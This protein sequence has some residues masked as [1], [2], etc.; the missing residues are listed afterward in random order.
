MRFWI[1]NVERK[2]TSFW[3]QLPH[4]KFYPDFV[5]ML[6]DGRIVVVEYKGGHLYEA[7][8]DKRQIGAVWADATGGKGLFCTPT[9]RRFELINR[10]IA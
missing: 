4:Q 5:V 8:K 3:L 9:D 10:T 1:R 6:H 2:R 7:A